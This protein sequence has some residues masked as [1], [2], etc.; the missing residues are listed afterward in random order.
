VVSIPSYF[1][2]KGAEITSAPQYD[3]YSLVALATLLGLSTLFLIYSVRMYRRY[4][5]F[6][7]AY[8][9]LWD[10]SFKMRCI[11]CKKPLKNSTVGPEVFFCSD[12][13]CNSEHLLMEDDG[14]SITK[15]QAIKLLKS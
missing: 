7:E 11:S 14:H 8:G 2:L 15:Q 3:K 9:V 4:G 12:P 13:K 1:Y 10:K 5:Q 6:R